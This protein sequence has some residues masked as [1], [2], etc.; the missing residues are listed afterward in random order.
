M[1]QQCGRA[2]PPPDTGMW[3]DDDSQ[4]NVSV[5]NALVFLNNTYVKYQ[6]R[7]LS[8]CDY[9]LHGKMHNYINKIKV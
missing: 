7:K 5:Q 3:H 8:Y 4:P 6:L 9:S 2:Y 1:R